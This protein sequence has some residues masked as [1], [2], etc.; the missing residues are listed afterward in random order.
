MLTSE[1]HDLML[2]PLFWKV[3]NKK[4]YN[5][6]EQISYHVSKYEKVINI[7]KINNSTLAT[8]VVEASIYDGYYNKYMVK[9]NVYVSWVYHKFWNLFNFIGLL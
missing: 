3:K 1:A 4:H 2:L 6:I 5:L 9:C 8:C 7:V